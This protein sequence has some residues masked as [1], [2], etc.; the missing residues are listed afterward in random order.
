MI[1]RTEIERAR[2]HAS[3]KILAEVLLKVAA[4]TVPGVSSLELNDLAHS[5]IE[6]AGAKP[7]FLHYQPEG[8]HRPYP[9]AI[10]LSVN[11]TVVHGIPNEHPITIK[12][13]DIVSIDCGVVFDGVI[14]DAT[15]TVIAGKA[16][17]KDTE[18]LAAAEEALDIAIKTAKTG[19]RVGDVSAAIAAV[20]KK[21]RY[22]VP[23]MFG[24]H[25]VGTRLH[26][27]PFIANVGAKGS[28][29]I[30]EEGQVIAIEPIF[31]RGK[32]QVVFNEQDGYEARTRDGSRAVQVEHTVIVGKDGG[33]IVTQV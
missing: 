32:P 28:G 2:V 17:P 29:P 9:A 20:A 18:F 27:E 21:Y 19:A 26:E 8:E 15:R 3:G 13:G 12:D 5:L 30:L 16:D 25:G 23:V 4:A 31:T 7:V 6:E 11:D 24:G 33:E 14:T 10:C 22:G 1:V